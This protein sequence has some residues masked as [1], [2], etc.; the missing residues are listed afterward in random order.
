MFEFRISFR[1]EVMLLCWSIDAAERPKFSSLVNTVSGLLERDS[2]YLTLTHTSESD[3]LSLSRSLSWKKTAPSESVTAFSLPIVQ[4]QEMMNE[5]EQ[6]INEK[7]Q[8]HNDISD[9]TAT[10]TC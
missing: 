6:K 2:G 7:D 10:S 9:S 3:C 1:Y 5:L 8:V 4:E